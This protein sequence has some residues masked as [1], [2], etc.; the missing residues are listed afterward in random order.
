MTENHNHHRTSQP[1]CAGCSV[2]DCRGE[3]EA[4]SGTLSGWRLAVA[5]MGL[6]LGPI[7]AALTGAACFA[8]RPESQLLGAIVGLL[9]G[10]GVSVAVAKLM[11]RFHPETS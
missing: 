8:S 9:L 11:H 10:I 5:S 3:S 2:T 7:L 4:Y 1:Q 6:F